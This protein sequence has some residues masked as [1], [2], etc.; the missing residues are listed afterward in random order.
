MS[1]ATGDQGTKKGGGA[2][3]V[4]T[5]PQPIGGGD[6]PRDLNVACRPHRAGRSARRARAAVGRRTASRCLS[7]VEGAALIATFGPSWLSST[8]SPVK[9]VEPRLVN[10]W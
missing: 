3:F 9:S 8:E 1:G 10:R 4:Q 7:N 5:V 2:A 6:Q